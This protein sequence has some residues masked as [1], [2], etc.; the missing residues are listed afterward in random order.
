MRGDF[1]WNAE[2]SKTKKHAHALMDVRQA[3]YAV[4]VWR[5]IVKAVKFPG[6]F[7]PEE[8]ERTYDRSIRNFVKYAQKYFLD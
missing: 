7:F 8:G 3:G 1:L 6:V 5:I 4:S 2:Q